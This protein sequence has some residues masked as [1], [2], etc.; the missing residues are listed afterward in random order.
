MPPGGAERSV[1]PIFARA[2][3]LDVRS[4]QY[5][6]VKRL[7]SPEVNKAFARMEAQTS[8]KTMRGKSLNLVG[9]TENPYRVNGHAFCYHTEQTEIQERALLS[10][11]ILCSLQY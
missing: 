1:K 3:A 4:N 8:E 9:N 10:M 6:G 5:P 2:V 11:S 7:A